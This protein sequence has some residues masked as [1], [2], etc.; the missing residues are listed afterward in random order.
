MADREF[1]N[2]A[3]QVAA[4]EIE[5]RLINATRDYEDAQRTGDEMLAAEALKNY[6]HARRSTMH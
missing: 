6:S 3:V 1:A 5:T 2:R 4:A